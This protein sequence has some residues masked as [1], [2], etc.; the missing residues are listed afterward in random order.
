MYVK[1]VKVW[2]RVY[3]YIQRGLSKRKYKYKLIEGI[4]I[5]CVCIGCGGNWYCI[6]IMYNCIQDL[7]GLDE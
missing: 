7:Q 1:Y 6:Y 2:D 5:L 4:D 3:M